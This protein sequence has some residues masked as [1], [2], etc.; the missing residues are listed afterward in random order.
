MMTL[1]LIMPVYSYNFSYI[2]HF[3]LFSVINKRDKL[4]RIRTEEDATFEEVFRRGIHTV[5]SALL[6]DTSYTKCIFAVIILIPY[7]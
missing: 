3:S 5:P 2:L 1:N 4:S 6:S 7:L